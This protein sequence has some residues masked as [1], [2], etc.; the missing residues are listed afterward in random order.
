VAGFSD[1]VIAL[2]DTGFN[3]ALLIDQSQAQKMGLLVRR[4][5]MAKVRLASE[6]DETFYITTGAFHWFDELKYITAYV[7]IET[8]DNRR[9]RRQAK[10]NE[11][12]LLGTELLGNCR[13]EV[14]FP[15]R[16]TKIT[17]MSS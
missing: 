2:I 14:D 10:E 3:G 6:K 13:L 1:S 8:N 5:Q 17:K 15:A 7:V 11:Y 12:I 16:V 9:M 4:N